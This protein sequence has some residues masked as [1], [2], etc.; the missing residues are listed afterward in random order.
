MDP[1]SPPTPFSL[2]SE[3]FSPDFEIGNSSGQKT[4]SCGPMLDSMGRNPDKGQ[5]GSEDTFYSANSDLSS[6]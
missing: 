2:G 3:V 4:N 1:V 6:S 5:G